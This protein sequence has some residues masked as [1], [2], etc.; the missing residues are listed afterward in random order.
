MTEL[1]HAASPQ[2][3]TKIVHESPCHATAR[4]IDD[5]SSAQDV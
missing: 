1:E 4:A 3:F 2:F 5:G